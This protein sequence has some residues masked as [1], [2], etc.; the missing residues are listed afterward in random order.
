MV[1]VAPASRR[2]LA[3]SWNSN[4]AGKMLALP[5]RA[6]ALTSLGVDDILIANGNRSYHER[7][8]DQ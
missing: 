2:L 8:Q 6:A 4:T 1:S 3:V 5:R 7:R